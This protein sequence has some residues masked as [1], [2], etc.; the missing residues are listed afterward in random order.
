M[1]ICYI[2]SVEIQENSWESSPTHL[3]DLE[4]DTVI[5][6]VGKTLTH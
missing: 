1:C 4:L 5:I 6:S 3:W 2:F